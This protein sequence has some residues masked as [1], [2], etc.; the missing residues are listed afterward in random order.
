VKT[1][2]RTYRH[3][4]LLSLVFCAGFI[5][6]PRSVFA[7]EVWDGTADTSWYNETDTVFRLS[8]AKQLAGLAQLVN[9]G[10]D[11]SGKTVEFGNDRVRFDLLLNDMSNVANWSTVAPSHAWTPIGDREHPFSGTFNGF[12]STI[13]GIYIQEGNSQLVN[14]GLFGFIKNGTIK[15]VVVKDSYFHVHYNVGSVVGQAFSGTLDGCFATG[16]SV[17]GD[18]TVGGIV[19]IMFEKDSKVVNC[20]NTGAVTGGQFLGGIAGIIYGTISGC[21]NTG[22]VSGTNLVG[23]IVAEINYATMN[24]CNN[25]G[26]VIGSAYVGGGIGYNRCSTIINCYNIGA[27][28]GTVTNI[29]G[30]VGTLWDGT[31]ANCYNIGD[32]NG[33][34]FFGGV[35]G[36]SSNYSRVTNCYNAGAGSGGAQFGGVA[37]RNS[38]TLNFC[39]WDS[40]VSGGTGVAVGNGDGCISYTTAL[41]QSANFVATLDSH[42]ETYRAWKAVAG[43]YPTLDRNSEISPETATFNPPN[44]FADLPVTVIWK[45]N[46][47]RS[48]TIDTGIVKDGDYT[49]SETTVTI[50]KPFI[51]HLPA[52]TRTLTFAFS[53]GE[54]A[55]LSIII[56]HTPRE[57]KVWDGTVDTSW[58][59]DADTTFYLY[60]AAQLAGLA[61]LGDK[62]HNFSGKTIKLGAD[63]LLNDTSNVANWSTAAPSHAW[64]PI[65]GGI[66]PSFRGTFDGCGFTIS[67]VY[68]AGNILSLSYQGLFGEVSEGTI[69]N[70]IVKDSYILACDGVG[71]V[72]GK[73]RG[74]TV[75]G[76]STV[77]TTV[78]AFRY[79][80][81]IVGLNDLESGKVINCLNTGTV[82]GQASVGG[83][84]GGCYGTIS[85]GSNIGTVS[86]D[87]FVGGIVGSVSSGNIN[88]CDN[89]GYVGGDNEVGGIVG[90]SYNGTITNCCN[91]G[92]ISGSYRGTEAGGIVGKHKSGV[93]ANCYSIGVV[94]GQGYLGGVVGNCGGG[95]VTNCYSVGGIDPNAKFGSIAG[96]NGSTLSNC[97]WDSD[98]F[99]G[100]GAAE[101]N[102]DTC[103]G[104]STAYM[105]SVDFVG[106]LNKDCHETYRRWKAV[107]GSYP[108]LDRNSVISP[109]TATFARSTGFSDLQVIVTWN[110]NTLRSIRL[111]SGH[112]TLVEGVD[113]TVS[114]TRVTIARAFIENQPMGK[115]T[116]VF[117]F[118]AGDNATL[119]IVTGNSTFDTLGDSSATTEAAAAADL[120]CPI[121]GL[122]GLG[123]LALGFMGLHG[124]QE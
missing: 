86:G 39:Y 21:S 16:T 109:E 23:G 40:D 81:G 66:T 69:K 54:T 56:G 6:A 63:I 24:D 102:Y 117:C 11:F 41:M 107:T 115:T 57:G 14:Q 97:F 37:G 72:V 1:I 113:Y 15:N 59:N 46:T 105:K 45:G 60:D 124:K 94:N 108:T 32:V 25:A 31:V 38:G 83:V 95:L 62:A 103:I 28:T 58:Y 65:G 85:S 33:K 116:L 78:K 20:H 4:L 55:T 61:S 77:G 64:T 120:S 36:E 22:T 111:G 67:G 34:G 106:I 87:Y 75:E 8:N 2:Y 99:S 82:T 114:D 70:I 118:S 110:G 73:L 90:Q 76:C 48:I 51:E 98:V 84:V 47:L 91:L 96:F 43:G 101:G 79:A 44:D 119:S 112:N 80:G 29:G 3:Q 35:V 71:C 12:G 7:G 49:V 122:A 123:L 93:V 68:I 100:K 104:Y 74:G 50:N 52:G 5:L 17:N 18:D 92:T 27:V 88:D 53:A 13:S 89:T 9:E 121:Q 42:K 19:G 26:S 30:F 10:N